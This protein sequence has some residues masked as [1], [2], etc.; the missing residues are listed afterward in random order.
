MKRRD[1]AKTGMTGIAAGFAGMGI[2]DAQ[3]G[4]G[5]A[6]SGSQKPYG[7]QYYEKAAE[8]WSREIKSELPIIA[9]AADAAAGSLRNGKKLYSSA[10]F[11]HMLVKELRTGR[12][13]NPDYLPTDTY[14]TKDEVFEPIGSGDFLFFDQT[15]LRVKKAHDRGAFVVGV[16]IPY[17]PNRTTPKGV[18]ATYEATDN[19]L[20]EEVSDLVLTSGVPFTNGCIYYPEI[21]AVR[22]CP[23]SVQGV[24]NFYWMLSAEIAMRDKGR[25]AMGKSD[26]AREYLETVRQ[27][28]A[29]I[30]ANF[31]RIDAVAKAMAGYVASGAKYGN[32]T[33]GNEMADENTYRAS[34]ISMSRNINPKDV[35]KAKAGDFVIIG[36]EASDTKENIQAADTFRSAGL[37]VIYIGPARTEGSSG[38]DMPKHADWHIETF[39]PERDGVLTVPGFDRKICP[40]AGILFALALWMT[41]A[42]F[43]SHMI[44][45][46]MTP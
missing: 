6:A 33:F 24:G 19:L 23:L 18:L 17:L 20:T 5:A 41:N 9:Q 39:S 26:K 40:T 8:V 15:K 27:R 11:G 43:I 16:R 12:P 10:H 25:G 36:G 46:D 31:N 32:Y 38:D 28:G 2:A 45:Q 1:F 35:S 30:R 29:K 4:S 3:R 44:A 7:I 37:K 21:P 13:G 22:G 14:T 34:G 42:Q